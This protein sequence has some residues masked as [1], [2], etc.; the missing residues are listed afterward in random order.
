MDTNDD[1]A[2]HFLMREYTHRNYAF[3]GRQAEVGE[4]IAPTRRS[5]KKGKAQ[6]KTEYPFTTVIDAGALGNIARYL[7]HA[8]KPNCY[9]RM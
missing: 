1:S 9:A 7:N 2:A 6:A 5:G 8:N 3:N 4:P